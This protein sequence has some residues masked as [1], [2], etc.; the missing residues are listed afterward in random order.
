MAWLY[1]SPA[2]DVQTYNAKYLQPEPII[3]EC[4]TRLPLSPLR[5]L[6]V[7]LTSSEPGSRSPAAQLWETSASVLDAGERRYHPSLCES[8]V[9]TIK[10]DSNLIVVGNTDFQKVKNEK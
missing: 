8:N 5:T 6:R 4:L 7:Q 3:S 1:T 9:E 2:C 10:A